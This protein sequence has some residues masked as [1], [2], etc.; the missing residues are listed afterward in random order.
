LAVASGDLDVSLHLGSGPW[1][2]AAPALIVNEA[3][4]RFTDLGGG[5]TLDRD[6]GL[7]TNGLLHSEALGRV[8]V[9]IE[10][11]GEH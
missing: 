1:D 8:A 11:N 6:G 5:T 9:E 10:P 4:G 7:F 2:L 3:G